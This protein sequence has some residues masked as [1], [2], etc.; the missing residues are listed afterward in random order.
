M[1]KNLRNRVQKRIYGSKRE[2]SDCTIVCFKRGFDQNRKFWISSYENLKILPVKHM[3]PRISFAA[4]PDMARGIL[5]LFNTTMKEKG[6]EYVIPSPAVMASLLPGI[7]A[8]VIHATTLT[9]LFQAEGCV[10]PGLPSASAKWPF[11]LISSESAK[12][13]FAEL[14][15]NIQLMGVRGGSVRVTQREKG[16]GRL[17]GGE[18]LGGDDETGE[19]RENG[20]RRNES[21]EPQSARI[22]LLLEEIG[23]AGP[24][25]LVRLVSQWQERVEGRELEDEQLGS[26]AATAEE[27][28]GCGESHVVWTLGLAKRPRTSLLSSQS[29]APPRTGASSTWFFGGSRPPTAQLCR[30]AWRRTSCTLR[31]S[32]TPRTTS[33]RWFQR[34]SWGRGWRA[35]SA[36]SWRLWRAGLPSAEKSVK[37]SLIGGRCVA[38][39][40]CE[41][42]C[43]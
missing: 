32:S 27:Q 5:K 42:I 11:I 14:A 31:S 35:R 38:L 23:E 3:A 24:P 6:G 8:D 16:T 20:P 41:P 26:Q 4:S 40:D 43:K 30:L 19:E 2:G 34:L 39:R 28:Q 10:S 21:V 7:P 29:T 18:G 12:A 9:G 25:N 36:G 22:A 15:Y 17:V 33:P 13:I 37:V 1:Q